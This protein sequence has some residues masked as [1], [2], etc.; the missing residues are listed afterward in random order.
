M[1][2]MNVIRGRPRGHAMIN[3]DKLYIDGSWTRST[4]TDQIM[5][6]DPKNGQI[7]GSVPD[8]TLADV[9]AAVSAARKSFSIWSESSVEHRIEILT[10][11]S[12]SFKA[13]SDTLAEVITMEVGTPIEYSKIAM[14]N[15]DSE[16]AK[17]WMKNLFGIQRNLS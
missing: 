17:K 7:I 15:P 1:N 6:E 13:R 12:E 10:N 9:D 8:G 4:G 3:R 11:L 16:D 5:V 2:S 14:E